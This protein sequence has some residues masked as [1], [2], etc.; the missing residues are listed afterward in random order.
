MIATTSQS[1]P[2]DVQNQATG[3]LI[4]VEIPELDP[5]YLNEF[6]YDPM[7]VRPVLPVGLLKGEE[8][9]RRLTQAIEEDEDSDSVQSSSVAGSSSGPGD[10]GTGQ[11]MAEWRRIVG[12]WSDQNPGKGVSTG[13]E[14]RST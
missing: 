9:I 3:R 8:A 11:M 12:I 5:S 7:P 2:G 4:A 6:D 14:S 1:G 13:R 10:H